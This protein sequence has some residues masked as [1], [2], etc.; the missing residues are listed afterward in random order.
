MCDSLINQ[1][2]TQYYLFPSLLLLPT[3]Q[4]K[5]PHPSPLKKTR[6]DYSLS[7]YPPDN[8]AC[9][10]HT[11]PN[12][13]NTPLALPPFRILHLALTK[14]MRGTSFRVPPSL[15]FPLQ[16]PPPLSHLLTS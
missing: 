10:S 15:V 11:R 3:L 13:L 6:H 8:L 12:S 2:R 16:F 5:I 7:D 1:I 14:K 4:Q 9:P